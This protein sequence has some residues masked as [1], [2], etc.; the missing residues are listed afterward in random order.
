MWPRQARIHPRSRGRGVTSTRAAVRPGV[1]LLG[2]LALAVNLR[3]ALAGYPPLLETVRVDLGLSAGIAGLVQAGAVLM[4]A[5]GSFAGPALARH[6]GRE[7]ALGVA[8]G[9]VA[10]G[11]LLRGVP[12]VAT[13]IGGSV[14]VGLGIGLA[15]VL[16]TGVVKEHLGRRAGAATGGYVVAMMVGATV[17]SA[18]AV[19]LA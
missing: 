6:G 1:V 7:R 15:G 9:L 17:S 19:P 18:V 13:L 8:V 4:M 3:A 16:V 11:S 12:A 14:L 5:A 2:V 10:A